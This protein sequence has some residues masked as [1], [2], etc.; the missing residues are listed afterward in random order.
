MPCHFISSVR[1][2]ASSHHLHFRAAAAPARP[3]PLHAPPYRCSHPMRL[4]PPSI[5][6]R[7]TWCNGSLRTAW[8]PDQVLKIV[9]LE[10]LCFYVFV[11]LL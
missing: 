8:D 4:P 6:F 9:K 11:Q 3:G 7:V 5:N 2:P 10:T 1:P